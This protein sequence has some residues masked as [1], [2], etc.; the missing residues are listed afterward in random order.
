MEGI[1]VCLYVRR[2]IRTL[3]KEDLDN[4][5]D[6]MYSLWNTPQETG[7]TKYGKNFN[8]IEVL[9]KLIYFS[10]SWRDGDHIHEG[11]GYLPQHIK[12]LNMF[13][14]SIQSINQ[15]LSLPYWD[16]T[17]DSSLGL[18]LEQ[19]DIMTSTYFGSVST[20]QDTFLGWTYESDSLDF[21]AIQDGRWE[22][23]TVPKNTYYS[24][25]LFGYG[26]MR[27]PWNMNPSPYISRFVVKNTYDV[28][29][30]I[31][32]CRA[33]YNILSYTDIVDFFTDIEY[34]S[35]APVHSLVAGTYGCDVLKPLLSE[36]YIDNSIGM[37]MICNKWPQIL[38]DLYREGA[39]VPGS[40]CDDDSLNSCKFQCSDDNLA[41]TN[42]LKK[43]ITNVP[44]DMSNDG[45]TS[46]NDFICLGEGSKI[47]AGDES[48]S[49]S[50]LD[51]IMWV[52]H[53]TIERLYHV[54][55]MAGGF[56][57]NDKWAEDATT[58]FVCRHAKCLEYEVTEGRYEKGYF[59]ECCYGHFENDQL[60]DAFSGHK[61]LRYGKTNSDILESI[62]SSSSAYSAPY[63]YDS[64]EWDHCPQDF[65]QLFIDMKKKY[66]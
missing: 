21:A 57:T 32:S 22:K 9:H 20:P 3:S 13:E 38:K 59:Q 18:A 5:L 62:D 36:G 19:S 26:Y 46:W 2:E 10:S 23:V 42:I 1:A 11:I 63:I 17:I 58:E 40:G 8:N 41:L 44:D 53:P 51:P 31:P 7:Q 33:H 28:D 54:K 4:T 25:L 35:I 37:L 65:S 55:R 14:S 64:F 6:A 43:T 15:S 49:T 47:F 61:E 50:G 45:W 34:D 27:V 66:T 12:L 56:S 52:T 16:F 29:R 24:D 60:L 48:E 30:S 39:I